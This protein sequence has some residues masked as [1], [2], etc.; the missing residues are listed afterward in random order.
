MK[1]LTTA[2][3]FF[4]LN[5]AAAG[6][7]FASTIPVEN[8][9]FEDS[10]PGYGNPPGWTLF[11]DSSSPTFSTNTQIIPNNGSEVPI[12]VGVDGSQFAA[13]HIDH[14][15]VSSGNPNPIVPPD[16]SLAGLVSSSDLGTF[17]PDTLYTLTVSVGLGNAFDLLNVG[18]ALG[19]GEPT[20]AEVFP[21]PSQSPFALAWINGSDLSDDVLQDETITLNTNTFQGLIGQPINV[22][23]IFQSEFQYGRDA[24]FDDVRLSSSTATPEPAT[25]ILFVV[26]LA[27]LL[28][29]SVSLRRSC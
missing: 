15:N 10:S 14:N 9:S 23:L 13:V 20:L 2:L 5:V 28:V 24:Y 4:A 11:Y 21:P 3:L 27:L 1:N 17:A 19:T 12:V 26:G 16:G 22:S 6:G 29:R 25:V 7:A 18:L 8:P